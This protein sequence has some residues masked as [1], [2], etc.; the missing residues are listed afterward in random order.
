MFSEIF[1]REKVEMI[2]WRNISLQNQNKSMR[3]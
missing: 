3:V 1:R 2:S